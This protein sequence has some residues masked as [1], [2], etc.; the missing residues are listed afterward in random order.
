LANL[1]DA[2]ARVVLVR[3]GSE[4]TLFNEEERVGL[5]TLL[6]RGEGVRG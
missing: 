5:G 4:L 1:D 6:R 3:G 2:E